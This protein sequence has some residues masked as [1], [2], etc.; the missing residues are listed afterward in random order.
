MVTQLIFGHLVLASLGLYVI[1]RL[2]FYVHRFDCAIDS[3]FGS[4]VRALMVFFPFIS[5]PIVLFE[6]RNHIRKIWN[7]PYIRS[8]FFYKD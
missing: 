6:Q 8:P 2:Q 1:Q 7:I 5:L 3:D 4:F